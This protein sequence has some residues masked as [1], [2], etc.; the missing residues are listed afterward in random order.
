[1]SRMDGKNAID[2]KSAQKSLISSTEV[3]IAA[4]AGLIRVVTYL[5]RM[6][7]R[8]AWLPS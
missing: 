1:M 6:L 2:L 4:S 5:Q 3:K 8:P 7:G